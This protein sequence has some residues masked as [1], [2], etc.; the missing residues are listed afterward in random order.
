MCYQSCENVEFL[1]VQP[2]D[3][4]D[5][6]MMESEIA[7]INAQTQKSF[8]MIAVKI[9]NWQHELTPWAAPP[10]FGREPFGD[11]AKETLNYITS[12]VIPIMN[13][14]R[15]LLGGY[16]LAGLFSLWAGYNSSMFEGIAAV[17]PSVWYPEWINYISLHEPKVR[18]VYL[19]LGDKE[20]KTR[21]QVMARVGEAIRIQYDT[22]QKLSCN[23]ILEWNDGNHFVDA[24]KRMARGFAWLMNNT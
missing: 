10:V 5:L 19:S 9:G 21:N 20:E 2:V 3:D 6:D 16:S 22:L 1:L 23:T 12:E 15:V 7:I 8:A 11:G 18:K 4:H 17:S 24:D 14:T 13:E